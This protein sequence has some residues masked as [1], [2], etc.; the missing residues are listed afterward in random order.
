MIENRMKT[1]LDKGQAVFGTMVRFV[2]NPG[3]ITM[4]A[5]LGF[6]FVLIDMEHSVF[7]VEIVGNLIQIARQNGISVIVRPPVGEKSYM[8]RLL[9]AGANGLMIP[10]MESREQAERVRDACFY[11]PVGKRGCATLLGQTCFEN[12]KPAEQAIQ[13]NQNTF[14]L[15]QIESKTGVENAEEILTVEGIGGAIIGPHDLS[16]SLGILGQTTHPSMVES[17][18][19]V[20]EVCKNLNKPCGIHAGSLDQVCYWKE[21]GMKILACSN[22]GHAIY[23]YYKDMMDQY[24][25]LKSMTEVM[26]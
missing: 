16:D 8:A 13:A 5:N 20:I 2:Q 6:N 10:M 11:R 26:Q 7:S 17:I 14:I 15:A 19:R 12:M 1:K 22:D 3:V 18:G 9:D 21:Q 24:G 23:H 4:L 25:D